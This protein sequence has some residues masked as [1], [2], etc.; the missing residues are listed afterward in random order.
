[1]TENLEKGNLGKS[2]ETIENFPKTVILEEKTPED[3][4]VGK[5]GS[6]EK[7]S[8]NE[9]E[10]QKGES[11]KI[12]VENEVINNVKIQENDNLSASP[13]S[14]SDHITEET[15]E[16]SVNDYSTSPPV[17]SP[18]DSTQST[19]DDSNLVLETVPDTHPSETIIE[20]VYANQNPDEQKTENL[21]ESSKNQENIQLDQKID[22][23]EAEKSQSEN[24]NQVPQNEK[25]EIGEVNAENE[26]K[27]ENE[28]NNEENLEKTELIQEEDEIIESQEDQDIQDDEP[29]QT[30]EITEAIDNPIT[31]NDLSEAKNEENKESIDSTIKHQQIIEDFHESP[32]NDSPCFHEHH[33]D[34]NEEHHHFHQIENDPLD[35]NENLPQD[36]IETPLEGHSSN[37]NSP[38]QESIPNHQKFKN[39]KT[40]N[41]H[42]ISSEYIKFHQRLESVF[43]NLNSQYLQNKFIK[44]IFIILV[45]ILVVWIL[46]PGPDYV[47]FK[48]IEKNDESFFQTLQDSIQ[49]E[50][51]STKK[52]LDEKV[53]NLK[54]R[55]EEDQ[56]LVRIFDS[57]K[58]IQQLETGF[59][60]QVIE[61]HS[62][63][64]KALDD[65]NTPSSP[66]REIKIPIPL[67]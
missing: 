10:V 36:Q 49:S 7:E 65:R 63:I 62:E 20:E 46:K 43:S 9:T 66:P 21:Q 55:S 60:V 22:L 19:Q 56:A 58:K 11:S 3:D 38:I 6:I 12:E 59:Q 61:S 40:E 39:E 27:S 8:L 24:S 18:N 67:D 33:L 37:P 28:S 25:S 52:K 51:N 50:F 35:Q 31:Q 42:W 48:V 45:I 1:M 64:W 16:K 32:K 44:S 17:D 29:D 5:V 23:F 4:E 53:K 30:E 2:D 57:L 34:P 13:S 47:I 15:H 14:T 26:G 41:I 54:S